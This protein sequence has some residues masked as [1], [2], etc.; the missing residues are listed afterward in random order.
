MATA[1]GSSSRPA[2][3]RQPLPAAPLLVCAGLGL[4]LLACSRSP[5]APQVVAADG[6]LCDLSQ[7]LAAGELSVSCLLQPSDDPHDFRLK[8]EQKAQISG[9]GLLLI[10]GYDLTPALAGL[11]GAV[12]VSEQAVPQP[13]ALTPKDDHN[14]TSDQSA[15]S[16]DH[17]HDHGGQD[18]HLWH[19][20]R[21]AA[22][23]AA[24]I[25]DQLSQL[26]PPAAEGIQRRS[27]AMGA[28]LERL[29]AWNRVQ[30]N[31]VPRPWPPLAS[32]HRAFASL[33]LA[34]GLDELPLVDASSTSEALRPDAFRQVVER[35][36]A[37]AT[38]RLF[39]EQSPPART[40]QRISELSG[41]PI[42]AVPLAADGLAM[43]PDG[44][45]SLMAT[46]VRNTCTIVEGW[47]GRC[48]RKGGEDLV[49][50]WSQIS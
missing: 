12:A 21:Q 40:L 28:L 22:A 6:V 32:S 19:N 37:G 26:D 25:A 47:G 23:M 7:R 44:P 34:Y 14:H 42:A 36:R 1:P 31:S 16:H 45:L 38:P 18:P 49:K 11:P 43:G 10:S 48:D 35:L 17:G 8:P 46:L 41:V 29:D 33:A 27:R 5:E 15:S 39:A 3:R 30:F 4:F 20:P 13:P 50:A 9:A 24:V 2:L